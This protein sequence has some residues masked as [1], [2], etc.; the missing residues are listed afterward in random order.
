LSRLHD[1]P[2]ADPGAPDPMVFAREGRLLLAYWQIDDSPH[3]TTTAPLAI[4][5]FTRPRLHIFGPPNDE[6]MSGHPL[7]ARGLQPYSAFR[8]DDSSL[9]RSLERMNSVHPR[10]D[11]KSFQS[12]SHYI[13]TFH[14]STFECV[15]ESFQSTTENVGPNE[16][17]GRA[18]QLFA[19][20]KRATL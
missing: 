10:H 8:V 20:E 18:L 19:A 17:Y 6:A 14:D 1:V 7:A 3:S 13:F 16:E 5:R 9:I 4:V 15:A 12:L 2:K 11:P